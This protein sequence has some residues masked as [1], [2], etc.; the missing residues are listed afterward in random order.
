MKK[1]KKLL[2][3][4]SF[5]IILGISIITSYAAD[6]IDAVISNTLI[7]GESGFPFK[8]SRGTLFGEGTINNYMVALNIIFWFV[9][10]CISWKILL[11][12]FKK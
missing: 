7:G 11:K 9:V 1:S 5:I 10:I 4:K 8:D 2:T 3:K 6:L 12:I